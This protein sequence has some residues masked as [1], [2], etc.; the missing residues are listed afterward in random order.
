MILAAF[1]WFKV[2]LRCFI[3]SDRL[4]LWPAFK[5]RVI[6]WDGGMSAVVWVAAH[7]AFSLAIF[8]GNFVEIH[9]ISRQSL[10]FFENLF[11][12]F[13]ERLRSKKLQSYC[14]AFSLA[15]FSGSVV[16][17]HGTSRQ[18]VSFF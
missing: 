1:S 5:D 12:S 15:I 17:I 2:I 18:S 9:G 10:S 3:L 14:L 8:S 7:L 6:G 13:F 16:E 4:G 11:C